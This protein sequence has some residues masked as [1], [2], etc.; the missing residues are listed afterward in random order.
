MLPQVAAFKAEAE[1]LKSLLETIPDP[2][3]A[4]PTLFKQWTTNDILQ[5]LHDGDLLATESALGRD[6]FARLDDS[7]SGGRAVS[8]AGQNARFNRFS[9]DGVPVTVKDS[10][11]VSKETE[12]K[13]DNAETPPSAASPM[14]VRWPFARMPTP[15]SLHR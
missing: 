10:I 5:H 9:V 6:P 4:R 15:G 1:A 11:A 13:R 2:D 3:W 8:F 7:P 12:Y 14:S